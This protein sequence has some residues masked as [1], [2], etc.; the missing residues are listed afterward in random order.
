MTSPFAARSR[1]AALGQPATVPP[2]K[3]NGRYW[4]TD[5]GG[6]ITGFHDLGQGSTA[7][8]IA[9]VANFDGAAPEILWRKPPTATPGIG[10][11][12]ATAMLPAST[13]SV[14]VKVRRTLGH[15]RIYSHAG[16][17][18]EKRAALEAWVAG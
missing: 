18:A 16:C 10:R 8:Q 15:G 6:N 5:S 1:G 4:I 2:P 9:G 7:Y 11:P 14:R 12:A 17:G 3:L 13:I